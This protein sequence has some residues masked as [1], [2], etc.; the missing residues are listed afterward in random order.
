[1]V[2]SSLL[3]MSHYLAFVGEAVAFC[4]PLYAIF[5]LLCSQD[6]GCTYVDHWLDVSRR[7]SDIYNN[8]LFLPVIPGYYFK[9]I[10]ISLCSESAGRLPV[11]YFSLV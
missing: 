11:I 8:F 2:G 7:E 4:V 1:M 3:S 6:F 5:C 9:I 10:F